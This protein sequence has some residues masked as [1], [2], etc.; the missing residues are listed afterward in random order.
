MLRELLIFS[1]ANMSRNCGE[2]SP[3]AHSR[4]LRASGTWGSLSPALAPNAACLPPICW[5]Y[6]AQLI[7]LCM[8]YKI[9]RSL[10]DSELAS[11]S[12]VLFFLLMTLACLFEMCP[13]PPGAGKCW[14]T[15]TGRWEGGMKRE[16]FRSQHKG[17]MVIN[18][19]EGFVFDSLGSTSHTR[20]IENNC[21]MSMCVWC[22][23]I[24]VQ[25]TLPMMSSTALIFIFYAH[26]L[27][28]G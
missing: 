26:P 2:L 18:V 7:E 5:S 15:L 4:P 19:D 8:Q 3:P 13:F 22:L 25:C 14:W 16:I 23:L 9:T 6:A 17:S 11:F 10:W 27:F 24:S 20:T 12:L 1:T 28:S 21:F